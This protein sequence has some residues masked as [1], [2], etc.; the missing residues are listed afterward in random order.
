LPKVIEKS[1]TFL[2]EPIWFTIQP[3]QTPK[4]DHV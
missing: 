3:F 4:F 1:Y 2:I